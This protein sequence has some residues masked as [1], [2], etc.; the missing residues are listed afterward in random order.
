M[1][2]GGGGGDIALSH[3]FAILYIFE[4]FHNKRLEKVQSIDF[5]LFPEECIS[6]NPNYSYIP[7]LQYKNN[8][9]PYTSTLSLVST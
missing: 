3:T 1:G 4:N 9:C 2:D 7:Y 6:F 8:N 5:H